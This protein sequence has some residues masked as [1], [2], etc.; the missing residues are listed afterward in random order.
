MI[1][2]YHHSHLRGFA[3]KQI[4]KKKPGYMLVTN[5]WETLYASEKM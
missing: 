3:V 4:P 2:V 5:Q 1:M